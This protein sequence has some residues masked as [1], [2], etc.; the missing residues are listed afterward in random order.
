MATDSDFYQ[1]PPE[2]K[3]NEKAKKGID[4]QTK[5]GD[6][7]IHGLRIRSIKV[8]PLGR[9]VVRFCFRYRPLEVLR[10]HGIAPP[11]P[12]S[13]SKKR[14]APSIG[15]DVKPQIPDVIVISD[16]EDEKQDRNRRKKIKR[17]PVKQEPLNTLVSGEI[18]D[19]T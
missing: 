13:S 1:V 14:R 16:S 7:V 4:H 10:A 9:E 18:I 6:A 19:L 3:F 12:A 11:A 5:F 8:I 2:Q 17:E 15:E